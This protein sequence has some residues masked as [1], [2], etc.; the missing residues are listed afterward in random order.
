M[1]AKQKNTPITGLIINK[2]RNKKFELDIKDIEKSTCVPVLAI[3]PD[4]IKMLE[5]L[6]QSKPIINHAEKRNIVY[7]YKNLA[8]C[9]IGE[10]YKDPRIMKKIKRIFSNNIPKEEVNRVQIKHNLKK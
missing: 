5:S 8:S 10:D 3:L 2:S 6:S 1:I 9:I 4:D 7:E